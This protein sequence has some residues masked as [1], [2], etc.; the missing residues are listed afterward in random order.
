[1][2][3]IYSGTEQMLNDEKPC[4]KRVKENFTSGSVAR[5]K[6]MC[7]W[8]SG[9]TLIELLVVIA[10]I[11]IL[12]SMLLPALSKARAAAQATQC[13]NNLKTWG[14]TLVMYAND[15]NDHVFF[16]RSRNGSTQWRDPMSYWYNEWKYLPSDLKTYG[17]CPSDN[18]PAGWDYVESMAMNVQLVI[19]IDTSTLVFG[20]QKLYAPRIS[21]FKNSGYVFVD[22]TAGTS[23]NP[24]E[25]SSLESWRHNNKANALFGDG[26]VDIVHTPKGVT[27]LLGGE[28]DLLKGYL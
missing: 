28:R 23:W 1:M 14:N 26:H 24:L 10:I 3:S 21:L 5:V 8:R 18:N 19:R 16:Q 11:A 15:S 9:F 7:F 6:S 20:S 13:K 4:E 2:K 12:A 22:G 27:T 25:N 17:R